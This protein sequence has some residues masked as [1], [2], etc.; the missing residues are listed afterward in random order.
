MKSVKAAGAITGAALLGGITYSVWGVNHAVPLSP[1]LTAERRQFAS[2]SA[3]MLSYYVDDGASGMPLVLIHSVNAAPSAHE[4]RPLFDH[5]RQHRPVYALDLPGFGFSER[6]R[7]RYTA[8]LFVQAIVDFLRQV[9]GTTADLLA[10][11]LG[12]EF[13]SQVA[14]LH[15][16]LVRSLVL[17]SP[18]GLGNFNLPLPQEAIYQLFSVPLWSQPIFDA[19]TSPASIRLFVGSSFV[20]EP[21]PGFLQYAYVTAH[22]P[23]ARYAPL[24]FLSGALFTPE[25]STAVYAKLTHPTL[26]IFDQ[27]PNVRFDKL[28]DL[29]AKNKQWQA[30]RITPSLGLPHW[31][32]LPETTSVLDKF[33]VPLP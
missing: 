11:S 31:E 12:G 26:M 18:S 14:L 27:D 1:A 28:P 10:L 20:G 16:E 15:P 29:L 30:V 8:K 3:G 9:V 4:V 19:L 2:P 21:A 17:I 23:G 24:D 13:I 6:S 25:V 22:Q 7:R 5:Y 33:W 32:H